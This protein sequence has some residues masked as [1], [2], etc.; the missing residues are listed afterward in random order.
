MKNLTFFFLIFVFS[1]QVLSQEHPILLVTK[2]EKDGLLKKFE[3]ASWAKGGFVKLKTEVDKYVGLTQ[4]DE[5]YM[6]SRLAMNWETKCVTPIV[7]KEKLIRCEG[8][9]PIPTPRFAGARDWSTKLGTPSI[10]ELK[11]FNDKGGLVWLPDR[12][13]KEYSW[14]EPS[15]TGRVLETINERIMIIASKAAFIYYLTGDEK[16]SKFSTDILLTYLEGFSYV[17]SPKIIDEKPEKTAK[18]IGVTSFEVIHENVVIPMA[19]TFDFS[20]D[21][22]KK[23]NKNIS[24]L[25]NQFKRFADRVIEGGERNGNWNLNQAMMIAYAGLILDDDNNFPDKKGR[26][27]Y[28]NIVLNADLPN[29]LGLLQ[30]FKNGVDV[31]TALWAEAPGYG[32][33]TIQQFLELGTLLSNNP[34]GKALLN[35]PLLVRAAIAPLEMIYPNGWSSGLGDTYHTRFP[36]TSAELMIAYARQ[37]GDKETERKLTVILKR[38]ILSGNY[39]RDGLD[40]LLALTKYVDNLNEYPLEL[41]ENRAYFA[42]PLNFWMMRSVDNRLAAALYGTKGG[43]VHSNGLTMELYG[44]GVILGTDPGRGVS[45]WQPE[46]REYYLQPPAHNTVIPNGNLTYGDAPEKAIPMYDQLAEPTSGALGVSPNVNFVQGAFE[47]KNPAAK[48]LRTLLLI[49]TGEKSGFYFDIFRSKNLSPKERNF[50]DYVYHNLG[51]SL[52][53]NDLGGAKLNL[54]NSADLTSKNGNLKAYDYWKNEKSVADAIGFNGIFS[55]NR[56]GKPTV[57]LSVWSVL[58]NEAKLYQFDAPMSRATR[59]SLPKDL[60]ELPVPSFLIRKQGDAWTS[61][62]AIAYEPFTDSDG[63]IKSIREAKIEG[64]SNG[65]NSYVIEGVTKEKMLPEFSAIVL[66]D[67]KGI[68]R[69]VEN[70]TFQGNVGV[71]VNRGSFLYDLYLGYGVGLIYKNIAIISNSGKPISASLQQTATGWNY[72]ATGDFKTSLIFA[73]PAGAE[74]ADGLS[75]LA[76]GQKISAVQIKAVKTSAGQ[77]IIVASGV[78]PKAMNG[79]LTIGK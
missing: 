67:E 51:Q 48:Q 7:E 40:T 34:Q 13:T 61:P 56:A 77:T 6:T 1:L 9:A 42:K 38:E 55:L 66:D 57:K 37:N 19:L 21:Y 76:N 58:E 63:T 46:H 50:H 43:H 47:Y 65:L 18:I 68:V 30:A 15:K 35:D 75:L 16:Y 2:K 17:T 79:N 22:L 72:S 70:A 20:Y 8:S 5:K 27:Y 52:E 74:S 23:N 53:L 49:K 71:I 29:Q 4:S 45:Y 44:A 11:P 64:D 3:T 62:F 24:L 26:E 69:K 60:S 59:D 39:K 78:L 41:T 54:S 12:E 33:G 32:F 36:A 10:E 31:E 73:L 28:A 14:V 25:H